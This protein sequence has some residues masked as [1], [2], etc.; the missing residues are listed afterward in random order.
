[1]TTHKYIYKVL[2]A[3]ML[4]AALNG[5]ENLTDGYSTDPV[6]ITDPSVIETAKILNGAQI[7]LIGAYEGDISRLTGMWS[8]E[9]SGED[10]QYVG[11]SNY[12]VAGRDF[13]TEWATIY[14]VFSNDMIVKARTKDG[15]NPRMLGISQVMDA[16][17]IGL[18]ADLWGDVPYKEAGQ[19]PRISQPGYDAQADVYAS[20][21]SLLDSAIQNLATPVVA[22]LNPGD[23]DSFFGGDGAAWTRVANTL[24][25]RFYL[26]TK[27]YVRAIAYSDPAVAINSAD[28]NMIAPHGSA[29]LQNFNLYY[30]FTTYDR[31][32]YMAANAYAPALLDASKPGNRN[33]D[34]T[35]EEAR[36]WYYYLPGG[37]GNFTSADYEP[38]VNSGDFSNANAANTGFFGADSPFPMVTYEENLLIRAEAFAKTGA[39]A[40]ALDA[41]NELRAYLATGANLRPGYLPSPDGSGFSDFWG[42]LDENEDP[43]SLG[44]QYDPYDIT[45]FDIGGIANTEGLA[46]DDALL[47]EILEEKYISLA[48][49]LEVFNDIRRTKNILDLPLKNNAT[50]FPQRL[51]YPQDEVNANTANVPTANVGLLDE[52]TVNKTAY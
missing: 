41:L 6:E 26:H 35:N 12:A 27:D 21:Q 9:F 7:N 19:F 34:K 31:P 24:K 23:A 46:P 29:Y 13:N 52:T 30:S 14:A 37:G 16:M 32:G 38:N 36:L 39:P 33:N 50:K 10:R 20:V 28:G 5:C 45:D 22:A 43:I 47:H 18:A 11:L 1:M 44:L 3:V 40:D 49:Q 8:G 4:L 17:A 42:I 2:G 25:A 51:L 15:K 48:G